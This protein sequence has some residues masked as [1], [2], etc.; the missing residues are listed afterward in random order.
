MV[1]EKGKESSNTKEC[2]LVIFKLALAY[3][4]ELGSEAKLLYNLM[5]FLRI[6]QFCY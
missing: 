3:E 6:N 2:F 1:T 5:I 4:N